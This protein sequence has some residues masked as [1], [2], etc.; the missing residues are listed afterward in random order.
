MAKDRRGH[1][2]VQQTT[3]LETVQHL[4]SLELPWAYV[5][6]SADAQIVCCAPDLPQRWPQG[7]AF[8]PL[9]EVRWQRVAGEFI[10]EVLTEQ[11]IP[12][13]PEGAWQQAS[14]EIDGC[15]ERQ[16]LLWGERGAGASSS[17][18]W[19]E[20]RIPRVL[21]YPIEPDTT[22]PAKALLRVTIQACDYTIADIPVA[23]R[24][25]SLYPTAAVKED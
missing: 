6:S 3:P 13:L 19:I 4:L 7:R 10:V 24:W 12:P 2:F 25:I 16:L 22:P 15:Y 17:L 20:I 8:G 23:T 14:P 21:T 5:A 18:E 9:L 11:E 1:I